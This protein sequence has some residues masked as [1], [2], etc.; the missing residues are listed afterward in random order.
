MYIKKA[1]DITSDALKAFQILNFF[2]SV[3]CAHPNPYR[4]P[5]HNIAPYPKGILFLQGL[6]GLCCSAFRALQ[7]SSIYLYKPCRLAFCKKPVDK[8]PL[9]MK[10]CRMGKHSVRQPLQPYFYC[11]AF[12]CL[13]FVCLFEIPPGVRRV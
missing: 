7:Y 1:P 11:I 8:K 12:S 6:C 4:H 9:R 3:P 5:R 10:C 13:W 2:I